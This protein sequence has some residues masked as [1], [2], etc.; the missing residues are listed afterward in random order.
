[1]MDTMTDLTM[2]L[3]LDTSLLTSDIEIMQELLLELSILL[4][5]IVEKGYSNNITID[6]VLKEWDIIY[7]DGSLAANMVTL[8]YGYVRLC[9]WK[10]HNC[11]EY[12]KQG[13]FSYE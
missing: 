13:I 1:M 11:L 5:K 8:E 4:P 6:N 3:T 7:P 2:T 9:T 12:F 10:L